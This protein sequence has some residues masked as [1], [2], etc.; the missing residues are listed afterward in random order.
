MLHTFEAG[1]C[2]PS[3]RSIAFS[4]T[5]PLFAY[6][7]T[8]LALCFAQMGILFSV[9]STRRPRLTSLVPVPWRC[10][11]KQSRCQTCRVRIR[12]GGLWCPPVVTVGRNSKV[13]RPLR[14]LSTCVALD[15]Q[16]SSTNTNSWLTR[17]GRNDFPPNTPVSAPR[18][19]RTHLQGISASVAEMKRVELENQISSHASRIARNQEKKRHELEGKMRNIVC[20]YEAE[21]SEEVRRV[22]DVWYFA[23]LCRCSSR[24]RV[25]NL[26]S[27][28]LRLNDL[29]V[30]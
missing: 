3:H 12:R 4:Q 19:E 18:D 22:R 29:S 30:P 20:A 26:S 11:T 8:C 13:E 9:P 5:M 25:D 21:I 1:S 23:M 10:S 17:F 7:S 28:L 6:V 24:G 2:P 14:C 27:N 15:A 16:E